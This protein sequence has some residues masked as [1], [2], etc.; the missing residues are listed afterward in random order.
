MDM[1]HEGQPM[2]TRQQQAAQRRDQIIEA[3][4]RLFARQGFAST[5]TRQ[6]A[7]EAGIT[8]GLIF[9]YFPSKEDLLSAVLESRYS[10]MQQLRQLLDH[11]ADHPAAEVLTRLMTD[12][13][14]TLRRETGI[15][16]VLF[17]EAQTN[18]RVGQTLDTFID[19]AVGRLAAYL[20]NRI[21]AGELRADLPPETSAR[22]VLW[23]CFLFFLT[24]HRLPDEQW[25]PQAQA[26]THEL[27]T[28]WLHGARRTAPE[29]APKD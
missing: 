24:H 21:V 27:M 14:A 5:S 17:S 8:E 10:Y 4:L 19:E 16:L 3:A 22:M 29:T 18:P 28:V 15:S 26:F 12:W 1:D 13:L 20:R 9:H 25:E 11:A 7:R 6:I 2:T 23:P